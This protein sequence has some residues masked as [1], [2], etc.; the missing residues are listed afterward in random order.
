[1]HPDARRSRMAGQ[2]EGGNVGRVVLMKPTTTTNINESEDSLDK[3][4]SA[5]T[6]ESLRRCRISKSPLTAHKVL[7]A[8]L[9]VLSSGFFEL[10][11]GTRKGTLHGNIIINF[12]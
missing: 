9:T 12:Q 6:R 3:R 8:F 5:D 7:L 2:S 11:I 4:G 10:C 1:M